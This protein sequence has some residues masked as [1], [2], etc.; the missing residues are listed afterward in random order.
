MQIDK[1]KY[2]FCYSPYIQKYLHTTKK[3]PFICNGLHKE[4]RK[5]FWLYERTQSLTKALEDYHNFFGQE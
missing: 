1:S 3:I 5:E 2:Y 4:S